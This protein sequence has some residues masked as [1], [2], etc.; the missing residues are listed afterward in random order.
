MNGKLLANSE[1]EK[2]FIRSQSGAT[3]FDTI[4]LNRI[5]RNVSLGE[6]HKLYLR[7][8]TFV[9]YDEPSDVRFKGEFWEQPL[10]T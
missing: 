7:S 8:R 1:R 5:F 4:W 6:Q 3:Y 9:R 2:V 10:Y